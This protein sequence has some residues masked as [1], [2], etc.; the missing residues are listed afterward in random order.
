MRNVFGVEEVGMSRAMKCCIVV[1]SWTHLGQVG[2]SVSWSFTYAQL[3]AHCA[4]S[5][6]TFTSTVDLVSLYATSS[7]VSSF[8]ASAACASTLNQSREMQNDISI[9]VFTSCHV[10]R[11]SLLAVSNSSAR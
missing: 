7:R 9:T 6:S 11:L 2:G 5:H 3:L 8:L 1:L 10:V 4:F